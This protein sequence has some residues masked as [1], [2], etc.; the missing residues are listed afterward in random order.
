[1]THCYIVFRIDLFTKWYL[2]DFCLFS[3]QLKLQ[4]LKCS[5]SVVSENKYALL[6][7]IVLMYSIVRLFRNSS[8]LEN[9]KT[10]VYALEDSLGV[11]I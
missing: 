2:C 5:E 6:E 1:M 9:A 10:K 11:V 8:F 4:Y 3:F 7:Y